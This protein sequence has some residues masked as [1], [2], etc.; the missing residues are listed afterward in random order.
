MSIQKPTISTNAPIR[1]SLNQLITNANKNNQSSAL[2]VS[3]KNKSV[4]YPKD[5]PEIN[6]QLT[7]T[8][9]QKKLFSEINVFT[10]NLGYIN[11]LFAYNFNECKSLIN[12]CHFEDFFTSLKN[13]SANDWFTEN[14]L[15]N[16]RT[17]FKLLDVS[18]QI[19]IDTKQDSIIGFNQIN[20][21]IDP[22]TLHVLYVYRNGLKDI[23]ITNLTNNQIVE[24]FNSVKD[25]ISN[26]D[27]EP[28]IER[29]EVNDGDDLNTAC[30]IVKT[31]E[32]KFLLI[33]YYY[34]ILF[35]QIAATQDEI[36]KRR[37]N[38]FKEHLDD[39][40]YRLKCDG[41]SSIAKI[42]LI[43]I[44]STKDAVLPKI[45][46]QASLLFKMVL[47]MTNLTTLVFNT[48]IINNLKNSFFDTEHNIPII[49]SI[50]DNNTYGCEYKDQINATKF[51]PLPITFSF[52]ARKQKATDNNNSVYSVD[53]FVIDN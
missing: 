37:R 3:F 33:L 36:E 4:I 19:N 53:E 44:A 12:A 35:S 31:L 47:N 9:A 38:A 20:I 10:P 32:V 5:V 51:I 28:Q 14:T 1:N 41:L 42:G 43:L 22:T 49:K 26:S 24:L 7:Q 50:Q 16:A 15:N 29:I 11:Y 23:A 18:D 6:N 27:Q 17:I 25:D 48:R 34:K 8:R 13:S 2:S 40:E 46:L 39:Y 52:Q 30:Y 45:I 21:L